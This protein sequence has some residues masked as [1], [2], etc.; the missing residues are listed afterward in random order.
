MKVRV[1]GLVLAAAALV[2]ATLTAFAATSVEESEPS[3]VVVTPPPVVVEEVSEPAQPKTPSYVFY[4]NEEPM[5]ALVYQV[6]NSTYYVT[7]ESFV[8]ALD[9]EALVEEEDGTVTVT[10]AALAQVVDVKTENNGLTDE[11]VGE[12]NVEEETLNLSARDGAYYAQANGRFLYVE[13]GIISVDGKVALPVRV[14]AEVYNLD[15]AYDAQ[16]Q[17]VHLTAQEGASAYLEDA[18]S[19]YDSET[20]YWLSHIIYA[21]SGNQCLEG[22]LAVGNVVMNR[23]AH[24]DFP[25][26]IYEVLFQKNQFSP[27]GSGSIYRDPNEQSVVA[28]KLVLDGAEVLENAL[29][30]NRA[31]MN[32]RAARNR[33]F[34]ATI[35]AHSF[36]A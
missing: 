25:D 21:E 9:C 2:S 18:D 26:T 30:F 12:A 4:V 13:D 19:Y 15:V 32:T 11:T 16:T 10:A 22:K 29:F 17:Q 6:Q 7:V 27:A 23:V 33:P 14:L 24:P 1:I 8:A 28:A 3:V 5:D 20:L 34:V 35:G 36:Y 31:G